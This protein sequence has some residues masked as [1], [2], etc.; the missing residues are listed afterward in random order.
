M[1][2]LLNGLNRDFA[3]IYIS[4][5]DEFYRKA[6]SIKMRFKERRGY[7]I[8]NIQKSITWPLYVWFIKISK[9]QKRETDDCRE[10][11]DFL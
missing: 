10:Q 3:E 4:N 7:P 5:N 2:S 8:V 1:L 6:E 9:A 11:I